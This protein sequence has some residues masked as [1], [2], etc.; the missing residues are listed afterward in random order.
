MMKESSLKERGVHNIHYAYTHSISIPNIRA[1]GSVIR[2]LKL[3]H[4]TVNPESDRMTGH[5]LN[6]IHALLIKHSRDAVVAKLTIDP[7]RFHENLLM[8]IA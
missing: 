6:R 7:Q 2:L 1:F 3:S 8:E 4:Y 5:L